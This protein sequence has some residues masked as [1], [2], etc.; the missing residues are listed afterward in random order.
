MEVD[1]KRMAVV[2]SAAISDETSK[3]DDEMLERCMRM[4]KDGIGS[5]FASA[6]C[7]GNPN[8]D[9]KDV[10]LLLSVGTHIGW[11]ARGMMDGELSPL[12][13]H[14]MEQLPDFPNESSS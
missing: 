10:A 1:D 9:W 2:L 12:A 5:D 7:E 14:L 13:Q 11:V 4:F 6:Y 3:V 8:M